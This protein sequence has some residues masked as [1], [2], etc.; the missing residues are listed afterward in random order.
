MGKIKYRQLRDRIEQKKFAPLYYFH[1]E[2]NYLQ[3]K[4]VRQLEKIN[5]DDLAAKQVLWGKDLTLNEFVN[6]ISTVPLFTS[7]GAAEI[8]L[9]RGADSIKQA[10]EKQIAGYLDIPGKANTFVN[11]CIF[12]NPERLRRNELENNPLIN[13]IAGIGEVVEFSKLYD[14]EIIEFIIRELRTYDKKIS[15]SAAEHILMFSGDEL[16]NLSNE[17]QKL[18]SFVGSAAEINIDDIETCSGYTGQES[19]YKL[20]DAIM[21]EN[22]S[23]ASRILDDLIE[24]GENAIRIINSIYWNY[25]KAV[26]AKSYL[27]NKGMNSD[28][29]IRRMGMQRYYGRIFLD[30]VKKL[31]YKDILKKIELLH[32]TDLA[33]KSGKEEARV[34]LQ[35]LVLL[36]CGQVH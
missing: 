9:L 15:R 2:E 16:F 18:V 23:L 32:E 33:I 13:K 17:I 6:A 28:T 34:G 36:L 27:E 21:S 26:A 35:T 20:N 19:I 5:S 31:N 1:G 30:K 10:T 4:T 8:V 25:S 12:I 29:I 7:P 3:E 11:L 14:N 24:H 22:K